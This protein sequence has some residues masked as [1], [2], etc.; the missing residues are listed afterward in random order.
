LPQQPV[1]SVDAVT[2][3]NGD[4]VLFW[5]ED[6]RVRVHVRGRREPV[7]VTF[8]FGFTEPPASL[9]RWACVLVS[10]VL[11]PLE[12]QLGLTAGGL[13]SVQLD[14]FRAA[15]A[16]AGDSTGITLADRNIQLLRDQ[17]GVRGTTVVG[18]R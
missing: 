5:D 9:V 14:D 16:D 17:F 3:S 12:Q 15:F 13:S 18:S 11:L 6:D 7:S 10:Q 1:V 4:P 8:T 2:D